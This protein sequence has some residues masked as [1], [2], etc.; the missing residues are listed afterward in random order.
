M[1]HVFSVYVQ[2][3]SLE[4]MVD[5]TVKLFECD[6][7]EMYSYILRLCSKSFPFTQSANKG[8][9]RTVNTAK[10]YQCLSKS[11]HVKKTKGK[12]NTLLSPERLMN[13]GSFRRTKL[14]WDGAVLNSFI[15]FLIVWIWLCSN[16]PPPLLWRDGCFVFFVGLWL[17]DRA[18]S[19]QKQAEDMVC[20]LQV[21]AELIT[22]VIGVL[23]LIVNPLPP[24]PCRHTH[25]HTS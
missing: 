4:Q 3:E 1:W 25:S 14:I 16:N 17:R 13:W 24:L 21:M 15:L 10:T 11:L 2:M 23:K 19:S 12:R 8:W 9:I 5:M 7:D 18:R 22:I 20:L 6:R